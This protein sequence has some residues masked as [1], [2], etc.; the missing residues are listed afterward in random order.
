MPVAPPAPVAPA[1]PSARDRRPAEPAAGGARRHGAVRPTVAAARR[2]RRQAARPS[3]PA[4]SGGTAAR[5]CSGRGAVRG[6]VRG[7][8]HGAGHGARR[9]AAPMVFQSYGDPDNA[10]PL[11]R[12]DPP[13]L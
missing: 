6:A 12:L 2:G 1:A 8:G 7:A 10:N 5:G 4:L 13:V 3:A 9:G 11:P